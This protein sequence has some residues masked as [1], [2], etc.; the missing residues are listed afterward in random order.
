MSL[1]GFPVASGLPQLEIASNAGLM[2]RIFQTHLQPL[3]NPAY[4]I[5]DCL[6][7]RL[8]YRRADR[9]MLQYTLRLVETKT[10]RKWNLWVT[11]VIDVQDRARRMWQKLRAADLWEKRPEGSLTFEPITFVPDLKMFVQ[12]FPYDRW[13]PTLPLLMAGPSPDLE[14]LLLTRFGSGAW[15]AEGWS[16]APVRY[17]SGLSAVLQYTVQARDAATGRRGERRF[18]V[19][20]YRQAE[21]EH[22]Y[23]VL[24]ALAERAEAGAGPFSLGTPL[25]YLSDLQALVLDEV[26]GPSLQQILIE[27]RDPVAAVRQVA[28]ALARF[29]Q[30]D[31]DM[32]RRYSPEDDISKLKRDGAL[33]HWACPHLTAEVEAIVC[34]VATGLKPVPSMPTHRD[35]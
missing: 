9:C 1:E 4:R 8:R 17:R 32:T 34:A 10:G 2:R 14:R 31:A 29:N 5:Q 19:K 16:I 18:Y 23:H 21:G 28:Q 22:T 30:G 15:H 35:L 6:L 25:I 20:V 11:G 24:R 33:L 3:T 7:S 26:P 12:V 27:G 13:L